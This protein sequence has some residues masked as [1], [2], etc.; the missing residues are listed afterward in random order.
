MESP[1]T[2]LITE[3][4]LQGTSFV[5]AHEVPPEGL[6][7][8]PSATSASPSDH[9]SPLN[10]IE[11]IA[12]ATLDV[13]P[14]QEQRAYYLPSTPH[15]SRWVQEWLE[16]MQILPMMWTAYT[17]CQ[18][19]AWLCDPLAWLSL[20]HTDLGFLLYHRRAL[21]TWALP[22]A[23]ILR[24]QL[25]AAM[26]NYPEEGHFQL[27]ALIRDG[28]IPSRALE[29]RNDAIP[30]RV[31]VDAIPAHAVATSSYEYALDRN[32]YY[33]MKREESEGPPGLTDSDFDSLANSDLDSDEQSELTD[34]DFDS[35]TSS[36]GGC[37][38][39]SELESSSDSDSTTNNDS[40]S[41]SE[42]ESEE[43]ENEGGAEHDSYEVYHTEE[44]EYD[45]YEVYHIEEDIFD[46][47]EED[48][49]DVIHIHV[50]QEE[51]GN[52]D[53]SVSKRN[54]AME[55]CRRNHHLEKGE[56][57]VISTFPQLGATKLYYA[58]HHNH[59]TYQFNPVRF[60]FID[61]LDRGYSATTTRM[62][63][64]ATE[65]VIYDQISLMTEVYQV[66]KVLYLLSSFIGYGPR[67]I[68][69]SRIFFRCLTLYGLC[70]IMQH[71]AV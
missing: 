61:P 25:H 1:G 23:N 33:K 7:L 32:R 34:S 46:D 67:N 58:H 59:T 20:S 65:Q 11:C 9:Y 8:P 6:T 41:E 16:D 66:I 36:E 62:I 22:F 43:S 12:I 42:S 44:D 38:C 40:G 48:G 50:Y 29:T 54:K 37:E 31:W 45:L 15:L 26:S 53:Q 27:L 30:P 35:L 69:P 57:P 2:H 10:Q 49:D 28:A 4:S 56:S 5:P 13:W 24:L 52:H 21:L 39:E 71:Y 17:A 55:E 70:L 68:T 47:E 19:I 14:E 63:S 60:E 51:E 64:A 3:G 18:L